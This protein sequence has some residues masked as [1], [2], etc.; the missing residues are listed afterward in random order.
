MAKGLQRSIARGPQSTAPIVKKTIRLKDVEFEVDGATGNG[1]GTLVIGDFPEG[2]ILVLGAAAYMT[3]SGPGDSGDLTDTWAGDFGIGTAPIT[4]GAIT[5]NQQN[6]IAETAVG[7]A[8]GEVAPLKRATNHTTHFPDNTD[9]SLEINLNFKVADA[10]ISGD[11][12]TFKVTGE[13]YYAYIV[14]GDD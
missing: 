9:G 6:I 14:L 2:N 13:F 11:D 7:P 3:F 8:V 5:G 4:S 12:I 1:W 10:N